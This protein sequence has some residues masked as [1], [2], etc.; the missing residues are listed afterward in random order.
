MQ[1][2]KYNDVIVVVGG[3]G[4]FQRWPWEEDKLNVRDSPGWVRNQA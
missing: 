4:G 1:D 3:G 2:Q